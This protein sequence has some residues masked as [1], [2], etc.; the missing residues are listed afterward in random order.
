[1]LA[2]CQEAVLQKKKEKKKAGLEICCKP[3]LHPHIHSVEFI[4]IASGGRGVEEG[5]VREKNGGRGWGGGKKKST[6][7]QYSTRRHTRSV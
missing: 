1:M 3:H 4:S 5:G 2:A 7:Q 6:V